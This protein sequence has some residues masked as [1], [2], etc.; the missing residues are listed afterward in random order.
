M[1][2]ELVCAR[3][4]Y[5]SAAKSSSGGDSGERGSQGGRCGDCWDSGI[6]GRIVVG[7]GMGVG[8]CCGRQYPLSITADVLLGEERVCLKKMGDTRDGFARRCPIA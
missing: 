1:S 8:L 4:I 7:V 2:D 6:G 3:P 5:S